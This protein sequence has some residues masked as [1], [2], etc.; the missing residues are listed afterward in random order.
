MSKSKLTVEETLMWMNQA[1]GG[2]LPNING[3]VLKTGTKYING[4]AANIEGG[5]LIVEG[6]VK[7]VGTTNFPKGNMLDEG[8]N[9]LVTGVRLLMDT[10][11][12]VTLAS[13]AWKSEAPA[14]WKNGELTISQTGAGKLFDSPITDVANSK[15]AT[16]NDDDFRDVIPFVIRG[17]AAFEIEVVLGTGAVA[18]Q[19]YR[20]ELRVTEIVST[21]KN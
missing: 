5:R 8:V 9:Y 11:T 7:K 21:T 19:A 15:I 20:L 2:S 3:Q 6:T 18:D 16:S 14:N 13:A 10:T 12:G 1:K 17:G 4:L